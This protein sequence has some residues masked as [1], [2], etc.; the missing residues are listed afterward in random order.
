LCEIAAQPEGVLGRIRKRVNRDNLYRVWSIN[1]GQ[2]GGLNGDMSGWNKRRLWE[3]LF[4]QDLLRVMIFVGGEG[5]HA[6]GMSV[7]RLSEALPDEPA[8]RMCLLATDGRVGPADGGMSIVHIVPEALD[9]RMDFDSLAERKTLLGSAGVIVLDETTCIVRF[10]ARTARFY[11]E[12]SCGQCTQCREGTWWMEQVL[13][14]VEHGQGTMNDLRMIEDMCGHMKG[15]TI[16]VLS[17]ACAMPVEV[18]IQKF[19]SEFEYH[20]TEKRCMVSH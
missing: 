13:H 6:A 10:A 3:Y 8:R 17:D 20:I 19:R 7:V 12:E 1:W 16:C 2:D 14:R 18:M 15:V 5:L 11:A 9:V 4:E